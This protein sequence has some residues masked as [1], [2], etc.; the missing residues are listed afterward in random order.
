MKAYILK[1]KSTDKY[2]TFELSWS[3][4]YKQ[5]PRPVKF[6]KCF[7]TKQMAERY[8]SQMNDK[9]K[10]ELYIVEVEIKENK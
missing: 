2:F 7:K 4:I 9:S 6:D 1:E 8:L 5:N 3:N 10:N